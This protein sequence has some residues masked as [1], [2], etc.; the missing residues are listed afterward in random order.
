MGAA[1]GP[2]ALAEAFRQTPALRTPNRQKETR[3]LGPTCQ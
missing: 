2:T 1:R 3:A